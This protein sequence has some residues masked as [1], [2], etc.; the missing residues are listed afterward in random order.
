MRVRWFSWVVL[1]VGGCTEYEVSA[2]ADAL[3]GADT[4]VD[5]ADPYDEPDEPPED[6]DDPCTEVVTA[7][8]IE[9]LSVL[10]DAA[11][12]NL[13]SY[14]SGLAIPWYRDALVLNYMPDD[15]PGSS[16]RVSAVE[17]LIMVATGRFDSQP[18]GETLSI[19]VF[20]GANPRMAPTWKVSQPVIHGDLDWSDYS[21]PWDAAISGASGEYEQK[22]AWLRYDFTSTIP[23][24]G[25][26]SPEFV[27]GVQWEY[28]SRVAVGYSNF[29]RA[30]DRNWTEWDPG[31]GWIMNGDSTS[32]DGCSWPMLRVEIERT[33]SDDCE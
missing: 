15:G 21:L 27:V 9:E 5:T 12:P 29:N 13:V 24:S 32:G 10:Q 20:D 16:W 26:V 4:E 1:L 19:E 25:M 17:V 2:K 30:C 22:G 11:S 31:S 23:D 18:D 28:L 14:A 8:D 3:A 6:P 33:F 7:F